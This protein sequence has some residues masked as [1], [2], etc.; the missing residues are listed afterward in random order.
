MKGKL[1]GL[2]LAI[3]G[4]LFSCA[5]LLRA[6]SSCPPCPNTGI[7]CS[8]FT[9]DINQNNNVQSPP[10]PANDPWPTNQ[11]VCF[12]TW[13]TLDANGIGPDSQLQRLGLKWSD[14]N[15]AYGQY[16]FSSLDQWVNQLTGQQ[17]I[18]TAFWT[19]NWASA[20]P[21]DPC[22]P[23]G[24][25]R[26]PPGGCDLPDP[27]QYPNAWHDFIQA[28]VTHVTGYHPNPV[29][30]IE[31]WNEPNDDNKCNRNNNCNPSA[32]VGLTQT[33]QSIAGPAGISIISPPVTGSGVEAGS[34]TDGKS[35][36]E[37]LL[38]NGVGNY[39]NVIAFHAYVDEPVAGN[40]TE[41]IGDVTDLLNSYNFTHGFYITEGSWLNNHDEI[42]DYTDSTD[43]SEQA[44]WLATSY[45]TSAYYITPNANGNYLLGYSFYG[46][47]YGPDERNNEH[48]TALWCTTWCDTPPGP[49][50]LTK[51]GV[52]YQ[53][54][55][56]WL[57]GATPTGQCTNSGDGN[58][59]LVWTCGFNSPALGQTQAVW[60]S[61]GSWDNYQYD[62]GY[63]WTVSPPNTF[64]SY[65]T[66]T[67]QTCGIFGSTIDITAWPIL[68][69]TATSNN[70]C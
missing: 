3:A 30:Y 50:Q 4:G 10:P 64:Y 9:L 18:F 23:G 14:I 37:D 42:G 25:P 35:Y 41:E 47:D 66:L 67:G 31:I 49:P 26:R 63:N 48:V 61:C 5:G 21:Q 29:Q 33:A 7:L 22:G 54:L 56:N 51:A 45:L 8:F 59:D 1:L 39:A 32:L 13:R 40:L 58:G 36:L 34:G 16:D 19:P 70:R 12:G 38:E 57:I 2:A 44:A 55:Y 17:V 6:Q 60:L 27:A 20:Y 62:C 24:N 15:W 53:N 69:T 52:G 43:M 65:L 28:L 68:L 11:D 46:W